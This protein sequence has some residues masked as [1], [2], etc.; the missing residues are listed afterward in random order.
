MRVTFL[1]FY[2]V[3]VE[4][5][6]KSLWGRAARGVRPKFQT[7]RPSDYNFPSWLSCLQLGCNGDTPHARHSAMLVTVSK[8]QPLCSVDESDVPLQQG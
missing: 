2:Y 7:W 3:Q 8:A 5:L 4:S 6:D 1:V